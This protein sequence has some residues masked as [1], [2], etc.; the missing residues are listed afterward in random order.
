MQ[1]PATPRRT[2]PLSP[3]PV[4]RYAL[5]VLLAIIVLIP[6]V[7]AVV[8]GLRTTPQLLARPFSLVDP[9]TISNYAEILGSPAFWRQVVN[10][11]LVMTL[12]TLAVLS[13][14][15]AAAFVLA[16]MQFRGRE[17]LF[18]FFTLGLLFPLPVAILPLYLVLRQLGLVDTLWG[19]ILPQAAFALPFNIVLLRSFFV[20]VPAELEDA[21]YVDGA[22]PLEFLVRI[23]LPLVRPALA[24]VAVVTMVTSWNNFFLPLVVLNSE[25]LYTLP[26]GVIQYHGQY[27]ADWARVLAFVSLA[28]VPVVAF[29]LVAERHIVTGLTAG[30]VKG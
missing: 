10:S 13:L 7:V 26:L 22:G 17:P 16:R 20:S 30:A 15:S 21:A 8:G 25:S 5:C 18:N 29:Y 9:L 6:L 24:A 14:S 19:V 2:R 23:L 27:L 1:A 4:A 28:L 11:V 3:A 12:T